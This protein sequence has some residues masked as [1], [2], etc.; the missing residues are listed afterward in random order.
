MKSTMI[1]TIAFG[2]LVTSLVTIQS[3]LAHENRLYNIGGKDYWIAVGSI[4]EPVYV[5]DKSGAE[6][7]ISLADP[8]DLLNSDANGTTKVEGLEKT[9]KFEVSAG[10]KKKQLEIDPAW[11][12]PGHYVTTF[13]PTVETT[14]SYRLFGSINNVTVSLD[15][16]C[17]PGPYNEGQQN[18]STKQV[19]DGVELKAQ[20]G[21][22]G[23]PNSRTEIGFPE[24]YISNNELANMMGILKDNKSATS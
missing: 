1:G 3:A 21:S 14:Y 6:A 22:F 15:Y 19:S 8:N 10:D 11:E 24:P 9:I 13:Y 23:C 4:N 12:D 7:F 5:D 16:V 20:Q 18:N 2:L 17:T